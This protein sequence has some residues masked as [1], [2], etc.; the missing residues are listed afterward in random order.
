ME[1]IDLAAVRSACRQ[2]W[3]NGGLWDERAVKVL[4]GEATGGRWYVRRYGGG[5]ERAIAYAGEHAEHY[6]RKTVGR[7]MRTIGGE[8]A[9]A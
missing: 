8:W 9:E 4:V 1:R 2:R 5:P 6:A 7:W 3:S